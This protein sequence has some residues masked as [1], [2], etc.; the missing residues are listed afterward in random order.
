MQHGIE[1]IVRIDNLM[2]NGCESHWKCKI[3]GTCVPVRCYNKLQF[4]MSECNGKMKDFPSRNIDEHLEG[5]LGKEVIL[6]IKGRDY[7]LYGTFTRGVY[8]RPYMLVTDWGQRFHFWKSQ[9]K[10]IKEQHHDD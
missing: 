1:N 9:I 8:N 3:C 7:A 6:H 10:D 5:F 4:A 2:Y